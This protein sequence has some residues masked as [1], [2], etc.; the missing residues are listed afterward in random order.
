MT[1][2]SGRPDLGLD[3][4]D[5]P[6]AF[7]AVEEVGVGP[8]DATVL[9]EVA[10]VGGA[11]EPAFH[12]LIDAVG[13]IPRLAPRRPHSCPEPG[14]AASRPPELCPALEHRVN[15]RVVVLH[16]I[17]AGWRLLAIA[18]P[19][20][21]PLAVL[22]SLG[23]ARALLPGPGGGLAVLTERLDVRLTPAE[24]ER[25]GPHEAARR[26]VLLARVFERMVDRTLPLATL[27][28]LLYLGGR[29]SADPLPDL[30]MESGQ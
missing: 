17:S 20:L 30:G 12:A 24:L 13:S 9:L 14:L 22:D 16:G 29:G 6:Y 1:V 21:Q 11:D 15:D 2:T 18:C 25:T 27:E 8:D 28:N 3:W 26:A 19:Q 23:L 7:V 4:R 5:A 10:I